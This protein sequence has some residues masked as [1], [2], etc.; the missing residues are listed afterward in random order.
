M[1]TRRTFLRIYLV[2]FPQSSAVW[3]LF[4][5]V[6]RQDFWWINNLFPYRKLFV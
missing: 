4:I 2:F 3:R 1:A 5:H 6:V